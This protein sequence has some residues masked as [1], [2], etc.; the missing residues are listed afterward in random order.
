M[1]YLRLL[2]RCV[3]GFAGA[4]V[5]GALLVLYGVPYAI[6]VAIGGTLLVAVLFAYNAFEEVPGRHRAFLFEAMFVG[7]IIGPILVVLR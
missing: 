3:L 7:L 6:P 4:G 2:L 1:Y 5:A